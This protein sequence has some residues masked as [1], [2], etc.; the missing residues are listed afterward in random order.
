VSDL[1]AWIERE[2]AEGRWVQP[3]LSCGRWFSVPHKGVRRPGRR[4]IR[5][6]LHRCDL[7]ARYRNEFNRAPPE[8]LVLKWK[9]VYGDKPRLARPKKFAE[10]RSA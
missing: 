9:T 1:N 4:S 8:W 2:R 10:R 6:N 3:C 7:W 5:C